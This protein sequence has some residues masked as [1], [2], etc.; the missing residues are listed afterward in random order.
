[1][2]FTTNYDNVGTGSDLIPEGEYECVVRTA[3]LN[4]TAN[5]TPYFD[6]RLVIRNDVSQKF[7]NRYIFHSL[8]KKKEPSEADMQVDGFS[9]A[10]IMALAKAAQLP[11][12]K[13]YPGLNEMGKDLIG[14]P[15][16]VTIEH[17]TYKE[18]TSE[19]VKY[20]NETK[21]PD[22]KHV[23]KEAAPAANNQAYAQK[24]QQQFASAAVPTVPTAT[25]ADLSDF[26]EVIS[27][28]D[29]PF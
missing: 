20:V 27:D 25:A 1:M 22:C 21:Y 5:G 14:K 18:K 16:R 3:A 11:A 17:N 8:W 23:Y 9:F 12:G 26:E 13:S 7:S 19:R 29:L 24:P 15:V 10:Q 4:S 6:V 2:N 28:S